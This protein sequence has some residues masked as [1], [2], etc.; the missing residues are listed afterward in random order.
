MGQIVNKNSKN[1]IV[2][3]ISI[4]IGLLISSCNS[5]ARNEEDENIN[6]NSN[7]NF[8]S[9]LNNQSRSFGWDYND[10]HLLEATRSGGGLKTKYSYDKQ[11]RL[12]QIVD[13]ANLVIS[14]S[15]YEDG[16]KP[17]TIIDANGVTTKL[18]YTEDGWLKTST[19][20]GATT[21]FAYDDVGN[22]TSYTMPDG[23]KFSYVYD[24]ANYLMEINGAG[25]IIKY[26]RDNA[27]NITT[28]EIYGSS[29]LV[30]SEHFSYDEINRLIKI[31]SANKS[32]SFSYDNDDNLVSDIDG[33]N[34]KTAMTW[35]DLQRIS[36]VTDAKNGVTKYDYEN[37][38]SIDN[39]S[40][41]KDAKGT[42]TLYKFNGIGNLLSL[43]SPDSGKHSY[44]SHNGNGQLLE[45]IDAN[46]YKIEHEYD[47]IGR[48]RFTS[49]KD[50]SNHLRF[51]YGNGKGGKGTY[52]VELSDVNTNNYSYD[53]RGNIIGDLQSIDKN[54]YSINYAYDKADH[55]NNI[56]YPSGNQVSYKYM[57]GQVSDVMFNGK[58]VASIKHLPFGPINQIAYGN[59]LTENIAYNLD[60]SIKHL[61]LSN[62]ILNREYSYSPDGSIV[63]ISGLNAEYSYDKLGSLTKADNHNYTYDQ[64]SNRISSTEHNRLV[65]YTIAPDSNRLFSSEDSANDFGYVYDNAGNLIRVGKYINGSYHYIGYSY[66]YLGQ[67]VKIT[68]TEKKEDSITYQYNGL[69]Q[70]VLKDV[71]GNKTIF[72]YNA[73]GQLLEEQNKAQ[74]TIRDY[75]YADNVLIA[76][77][78]NGILVYITTDHLNAPQ[79]VTDATGRVVWSAT[80]D[81]FG[82]ATI[83][84]NLKLNLRADGQYEDSE[85]GLY[86]NWYRYYNPSLGRYIT[87]DPLGLAA[88]NNTYIYVN[89]NPINYTDP[90]GLCPMCV[91]IAA[92][93]LIEGISEYATTGQLNYKNILIAGASGALT[94]GF[95]GA[96]AGM[97]LINNF[98]ANSVVG[99]IAGGAQQLASNAANS[100]NND[101]LYDGVVMSSLI[102][103]GLNMGGNA[104]PPIFRN[105]FKNV[106]KY[107]LGNI[108]GG[109]RAKR[110]ATVEPM[111]NAGEKV[112]VWFSNIGTGFVQIGININNYK[113]P[114]QN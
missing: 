114:P 46:G 16:D 23:T 29:G 86:Y 95:G 14:F 49:L 92:G 94:G 26:T 10:E 79:V 74:N 45:E 19:T 32:R 109:N 102:G 87:S 1:P 71:N 103:A 33:R 111:A 66:N 84:G 77:V 50:Q 63:S 75:I 93:M 106:A 30:Y 13:P 35:D 5:N 18:T 9:P 22:L 31:T 100:C 39:P 97:K 72:I 80:Y 34:N 62:D 110:L 61:T 21:S 28:Q 60:Y 57:N 96:T 88:G 81:P 99:G 70:R 85:T 47:V 36:T 38:Q 24:D 76:A 104:I 58:T 78:E 4:A 59:G 41:I 108:K 65:S 6:S 52:V 56:R 55:L 82:K 11:G 44:L 64:L 112:G 48:P 37:T 91:G 12:I 17:G 3:T 67:L 107:N 90:Q 42:N 73:A 20:D 51:K 7:I 27:G 8:T 89:G 101:N 53:E 25:G 68:N 113:K 98:L 105:S 40:S 54:N 83:T 15:D 43:I 69:Y 2:I